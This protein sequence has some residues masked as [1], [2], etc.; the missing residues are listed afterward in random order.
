M[1]I[2]FNIFE[3]T[4]NNFAKVFQEINISYF[5]SCL[6]KVLQEFLNRVIFE[7]FSFLILQY[8]RMFTDDYNL[9]NL[10]NIY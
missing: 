8:S 6:L 10:N 5:V 3:F 2:T 4:F 9:N 1:N 7:Y